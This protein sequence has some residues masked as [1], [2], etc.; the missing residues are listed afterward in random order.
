MNKSEFDQA[1]KTYAQEEGKVVSD[2]LL[3]SEYGA[4]LEHESEFDFLLEYQLPKGECA[5]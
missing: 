3:Q 1:Y 5:L 4:Y 2:A